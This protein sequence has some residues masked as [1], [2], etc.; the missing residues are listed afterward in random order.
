MK[1]VF[2]LSQLL[3]LYSSLQLALIVLNRVPL[4]QT[5]TNHPHSYMSVHM[6]HCVGTNQQKKCLIIA[7]HSS[8]TVVS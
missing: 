2:Y 6:L 1:V 8:S 5:K 7:Q 4:I 3:G